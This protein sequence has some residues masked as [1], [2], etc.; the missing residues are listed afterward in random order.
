MAAVT[1]RERKSARSSSGLRPAELA[2]D[3]GDAAG[4]PRA[5]PAAIAD[6]AEDPPGEGLDRVDQRQ[7]GGQREGDAEHVQRPGRGVL[8]LRQ[9]QR[10][11]QQEDGEH[12]HVDEE[13][14]APPEVLE[15][16]AAEDRAQRGACRRTPAAQTAIAEAPLLLVQEEVA[17]QGER[18]GHQRRAEDAL[19]RAGGDRASGCRGRRRP[20][21]R[22]RRTR[23]PDQQQAA[24]AEPVAEGA[25][26]D[27]AARPAAAGRCPPLQSS[28][29]PLGASA[30]VIDGTAK[31]ST[32]PSTE[33]SRTGSISTTRPSHSRR[34]ARGAVRPVAGGRWGGAHVVL[35]LSSV[36]VPSRRYSNSHG[37]TVA[38]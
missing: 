9:Q 6:R 2:A 15:Q 37:Q 25:G 17:E 12:R 3:E 38:P 34:P 23:R 26:G 4:D 5:R 21:P 33:I 13:D 1:T 30:R 32:V 27:A 29:V 20:A 10:A 14:R 31:V 8:R 35:V 18:R 28:S 11:D 19:Q 24:A 22:R 36:L 7:H 16:G